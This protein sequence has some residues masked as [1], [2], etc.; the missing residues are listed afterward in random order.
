MTAWCTNRDRPLHVTRSGCEHRYLV[1]TI[2]H[3]M[4]LSLPQR[5]KM[6][7]DVDNSRVWAKITA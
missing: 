3:F 7:A 6:M 1:D 4:Q 2:R 5:A